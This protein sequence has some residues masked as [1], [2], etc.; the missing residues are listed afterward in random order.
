[1]LVRHGITFSVAE[2][3]L[4]VCLSVCPLISLHYVRTLTLREDNVVIF[5]GIEPDSDVSTWM[6][7]GVYTSVCDVRQAQIAEFN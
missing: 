6:T 3:N 4:V 1:M 5:T 7:S 2:F